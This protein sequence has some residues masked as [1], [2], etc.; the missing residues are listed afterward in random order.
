MADSKDF[1]KKVGFILLDNRVEEDAASGLTIAGID[2]PS[3]FESFRDQGKKM[4]ELIE[5]RIGNGLFVMV[6]HQP[7]HFKRAAEMG[8]SL[9]LSGH[10]HGG[11]MFPG[12]FITRMIYRDGDRGLS[13]YLDSYLYVCIGSGSWGPPIRVGAPSELVIIEIIEKK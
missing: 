5:K 1:L 9:M 7:V 6:N 11:Q 2:D 13:Q 10:T 4:E 8:V 3:A 12:G